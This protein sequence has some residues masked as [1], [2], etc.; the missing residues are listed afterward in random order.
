M[1]TDRQKQIER[2]RETKRQRKLRKGDRYIHD[3]LS[4]RKRDREK[5]NT[6]RTV[7]RCKKNKY[8]EGRT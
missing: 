2:D 5:N 1:E 4:V 6:V 7:E 8:K 3:I